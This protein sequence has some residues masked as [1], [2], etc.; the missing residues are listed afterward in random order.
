MKAK[1]VKYLLSEIIRLDQEGDAWLN[2]VNSQV[3]DSF[4]DNGYTEILYKQREMMLKYIFKDIYENVFW[5]LYDWRIGYTINKDGKDYSINS[6]DDFI[7]Y[8]YS[9]GLVT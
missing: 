8:L 2:T 1:N 3:R 4:Y 7:Q 5:F 9:E 6:L